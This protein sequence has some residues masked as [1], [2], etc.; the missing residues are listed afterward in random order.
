VRALAQA[1][2][3]DSQIDWMRA[4]EVVNDEEGIARDVTLRSERAGGTS[5]DPFAATANERTP[6]AANHAS[7]GVIAVTLPVH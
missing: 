6:A 3:I 4:A 1:N 5:T 7:P 2:T